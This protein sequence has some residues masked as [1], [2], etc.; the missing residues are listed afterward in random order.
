[1]RIS[2][3][4]RAALGGSRL[5][6][7]LVEVLVAT[8]MITVAITSLYIGV[9]QTYMFTLENELNLRAMQLLSEQME[10]IRLYTWTQL[11]NN[12]YIPTTFTN[13]YYPPGTSNGVGGV[14]FTGTLTITNASLTEGYS[15]DVR[16]VSAT[17]NWNPGTNWSTGSAQHQL[18][19][20]T[21]VAHYGMQNYV[22]GTQ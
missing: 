17:V 14:V 2:I 19:V 12:G 22:Y 4:R 18:Q 13:Y 15:N 9:G 3:Y 6:F 5:A 1:M 11:T 8:L 7:T 20:S 10:T 21:L 16:Q